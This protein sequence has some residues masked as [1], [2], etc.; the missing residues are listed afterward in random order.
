[1]LWQI[2]LMTKRLLMTRKYDLRE[3]QEKIDLQ[4]RKNMI[5]NILPQ[6]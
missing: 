3:S 4:Y 2:I 6:Y 5:E 1:M